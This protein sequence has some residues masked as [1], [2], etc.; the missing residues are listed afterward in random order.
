MG[1][2]V[3]VVDDH[4]L[5]R[6]G[7]IGILQNS[8]DVEVV[9]EGENG[10]EAVHLVE[11]LRPD[12]LIIDLSMPQMNGFE[13]IRRIRKLQ[14][15]VHIL[16]LTVNEEEKSLFDAMKHGAQGYLIKTVDPDEL[17]EAVHNVS[18]GETVVPD[19]LAPTI[20]SGLSNPSTYEEIEN[21][22][23]PL[24][25][26]EIDILREIGTGAT[27]KDIAK[28]LFISEN[29]VR[30]HVRRILDKLHVIN[31]VAAATYAVREGFIKKL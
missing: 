2:R 17:V 12:V 7:V 19:H 16:I 15:P 29:T 11:S 5:F 8:P 27:N 30:N 3:V 1:I 13:A 23:Q 9:G 6:N 28:R 4:Q 25:L 22:Q 10:F 18:K 24:T 21:A 14:V 26:R 20:L 31:R